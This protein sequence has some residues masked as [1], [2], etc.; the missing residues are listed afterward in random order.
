[1]SKKI[2]IAVVIVAVI[3][4]IYLISQ[5]FKSAPVPV[6]VEQQMEPAAEPEQTVQEAE[7]EQIVKELKKQSA[8]VSASKNYILK[9][10]PCHNKDGS[11][12]VGSVIKGMPK[13]EIVAKLRA[14]KYGQ[15]HNGLMD[16]LMKNVSDDE[17]NSLAE[18]ISNF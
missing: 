14:Y 1:M 17:I 12:P 2:I 18:E 8:G 11:G 13:D 4:F 15:E 9:C 16:G 6:A 7:E 5:E 3:G 10:A